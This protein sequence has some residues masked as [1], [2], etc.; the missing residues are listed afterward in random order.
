MEGVRSVYYLQMSTFEMKTFS[1]FDEMQTIFTEVQL[2]YLQ[3]RETKPVDLGAE[4]TQRLSV[5]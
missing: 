1:H 2:H 5:C 4:V 3:L